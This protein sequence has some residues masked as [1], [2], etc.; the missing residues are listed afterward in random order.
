VDRGKRPLS[1]NNKN[2]EWVKVKRPWAKG[3]S[4]RSHSPGKNKEVRGK[5]RR[6]KG[7]KKNRWGESAFKK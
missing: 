4:L 2:K 3:E 1:G 5:Q 7:P 6:G